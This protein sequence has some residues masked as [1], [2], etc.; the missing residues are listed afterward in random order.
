MI[1][2]L[3]EMA[4]LVDQAECVVSQKAWSVWNVDAINTWKT[5]LLASIV[6]CQRCVEFG[7]QTNIFLSTLDCVDPTKPQIKDC[8]LG[9]HS[10]SE[11]RH[12]SKLWDSVPP[13]INPIARESPSSYPFENS[14]PP[15]QQEERYP[16]IGWVSKNKY[17]L[18]SARTRKKSNREPS[19]LLKPLLSPV[20]PQKQRHDADDSISIS[21]GIH[22]KQR[23]ESEESQ[24]NKLRYGRDVD[25][26]FALQLEE[27]KK[28][29]CI[30][31]VFGTNV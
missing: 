17:Q 16:T 30:D 9:L 1:M 24:I 2:Q 5:F 3:F 18:D 15:F 22:P 13:R 23:L 21:N 28:R 26:R 20:L 31:S 19:Q 11:N 4:S 7:T 14:I 10:N 25:Y 29:F 12:V 6:L 8:E 27:T